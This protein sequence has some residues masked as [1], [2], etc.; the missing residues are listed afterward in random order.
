MDEGK[1]ASSYAQLFPPLLLIPPRNWHKYHLHCLVCHSQQCK[2]HKEGPP[3]KAICLT[4]TNEKSD[5]NI[6]WQSETCH[7]QQENF[8]HITSC[9]KVLFSDGCTVYC[10]TSIRNVVLH[11]KENILFMVDLKHKP[12]TTWASM[13]ATLLICPCYFYAHLL[14]LPLMQTC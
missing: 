13:R 8:P 5:I 1:T 14:T 7:A 9:L 11:A 3:F 2:T 6:T 12:H 10:S 4:L